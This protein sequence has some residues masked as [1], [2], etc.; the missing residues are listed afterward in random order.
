MSFLFN[1]IILIILYESSKS[2]SLKDNDGVSLI[3][4]EYM[5]NLSE[6]NLNIKN[7]DTD[8]LDS[9]SCHLAFIKN[10]RKEYK[11]IF[12][13]YSIYL[14]RQ[15]IFFS[16]K[17]ETINDL[18]EIDYDKKDVYLMG[19]LVP[20]SLNYTVKKDHGIPIFEID[21]NY[22]NYMEK[23]DMRYADKNIYFSLKIN[24]AVEY[25]PEKYFL[26]LSI[27][28]VI[29]SF[30][31]MTYWKLSLKKLQANNI[32]PI[33][34]ISMFLIYLNNLLT[35]VLIMKSLN[36]RGQKI[37]DDE[38]ES[39]ILLD[40]ALITLNGLHRTIIWFLALLLSHGWN[41]SIQQF[42]GRDCKFFL[43]MILVLFFVLSIDQV[44]DVI[45]EP[46]SRLNASEIKNCIFY[47][48]MIYYMLYKIDKN[49][50]FLKLKIHYAQ[51][52]NPEYI[53]SLKYKINLFKKYKVLLISYFFAFLTVLV[54]QKA[55]FYKYDETLFE[56]YNY[57]SLDCIFIYLLLMLFRPKD[58]PE[59]YTIDLGDNIEEIDGN[60]YK[61]TLPKYSEAHLKI[62]DLN[63]KEVEECKKKNIPIVV[64]APNIKNRNNMENNISIENSSINNY[65]LNLTIGFT[66]N[67]K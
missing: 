4:Y 7:R 53:N 5:F 49:I 60:I 10:E 8:I 3:Y 34:K 18:L 6:I 27:V 30:T 35:F 42:N 25:Y 17:A 29:L 16:D 59:H 48:I 57:L 32:L 67:I 37:Y 23:W 46:I 31:L 65:F 50:D 56:I 64:I 11:E 1:L 33:N 51:L 44:I 9:T 54:L 66:D 47:L 13:L 38:S 58:L 39:S 19:L 36:V 62:K 40:T 26:I 24:H 43:R 15:W 12:E 2:T 28:I 61:Y 41:I 52:I 22:T 20:K 45:F 21:D 55:M 63:K 14:N